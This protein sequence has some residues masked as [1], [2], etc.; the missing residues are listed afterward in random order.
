MPVDGTGSETARTVNRGS[1]GC[2]AALLGAV[3]CLL[4][5][6]ATAQQPAG[7][8]PPVASRAPA[9]SA[10]S[11]RPQPDAEERQRKARL[12]A[13]DRWR[14]ALFELDEWLATQ[15][16]YTPAEVRRIRADL[17]ARV[18]EMSSYELEYLLESLSAKLV[19]LESR[20][21]R[22]AREWLGRYLAVMAEW[23]RADLLEHVPNVVDMTAGE[24]TA[25]VEAV[26]RK[27]RAV[28]KMAR[29]T[30]RSRREFAA[31]TAAERDRD[32]AIRTAQARIR[33]GDVAFSPYRGQPVADPP[34]AAAY[35]SP[36]VVGTGAW[37]TTLGINIG[38]L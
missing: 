24:L 8:K 36:T 16:V 12:L 4:G 17:A 27:R 37:L 3:L 28:E 11:D 32:A 13:S 31:F 35:D 7:R 33:R 15:P 20:R 18:A 25:A 26:E 29:E 10:T 34:F 19:I 14:R 5:M 9:A 23:K 30:E 38:G 2:A 21:A 22:E 1:Q 6:L